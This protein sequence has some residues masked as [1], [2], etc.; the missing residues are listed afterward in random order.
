M[1]S[2]I[3]DSLKEVNFIFEVSSL[4]VKD[5]QNQSFISRFTKEC[6]K[7]IADSPKKISRL[8]VEGRA[9][10]IN[11]YNRFELVTYDLVKL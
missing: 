5:S 6:S 2:N 4:G 7:M 1:I 3:D 11:N 10:L 8:T 9:G